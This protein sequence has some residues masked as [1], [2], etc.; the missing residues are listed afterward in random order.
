MLLFRTRHSI[1]GL[2]N[3]TRDNDTIAAI[4]GACLG[5]L[6][7]KSKIRAEWLLGLSGRTRD[8]DDGHVFTLLKEAKR[9]WYPI[10]EGDSVL[11]T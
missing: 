3:D 9:V 7:G 11:S 8:K 4:V 6:H 1:F 10:S 2:V 5:A